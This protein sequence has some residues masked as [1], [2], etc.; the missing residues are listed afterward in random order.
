[1][2]C[3][4]LLMF[5][6]TLNRNGLAGL[7]ANQNGLGATEWEEFVELHLSHLAF[8]PGGK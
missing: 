1:M 8:A 7:N 4:S 3:F 6:G 2:F 5:T